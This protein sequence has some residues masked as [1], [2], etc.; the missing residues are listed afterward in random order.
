MASHQIACHFV[1]MLS[2]VFMNACIG[3]LCL[4]RAYGKHQTDEYGD[5]CRNEQRPKP[6]S[7]DDL[8]R[9]RE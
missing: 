7:S 4:Q 5:G 9:Y 1:L 2:V 6:H 3:I 8:E